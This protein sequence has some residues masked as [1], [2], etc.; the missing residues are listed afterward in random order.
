MDL[1]PAITTEAK[2]LAENYDISPDVLERFAKFVIL[3]VKP[4]K[5]LTVPKL[6]KAIYKYF[7]V[8]ST[9]KLRKS[10]DFLMATDGMGKLN[11]GTKKAWESLY[12]EFIGVLPHEDGEVGYGCI[13]GIDIFKYSL[14]WRVFGLDPSTA[15]TK[16]IK[17]AY[18]ELSK[19]YHPDA[20]STGDAHVF[21]RLTLFY[22]S[23]TAEA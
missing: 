1:Y 17:T 14:P 12:R 8:A 6:K 23:L 18:R 4:P 3:Q 22:R 9:D 7:G 19:Q 2:R 21:D 20:L 5:P 16:D 13:N 10:S 11:L 15:T